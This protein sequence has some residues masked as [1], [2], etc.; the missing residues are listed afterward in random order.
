MTLG[1]LSIRKIVDKLWL[2]LLSPTE[3]KQSAIKG[4]NNGKARKMQ[5]PIKDF[6][7]KYDKIYS[8]LW[9]WKYLLRKSLMEN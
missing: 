7:S 4:V 6:F 8:F 1:K 2:V 5:F 9:I 3:H